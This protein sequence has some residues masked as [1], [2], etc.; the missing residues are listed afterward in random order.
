MAD[1]GTL[2][3][4]GMAIEAPSLTAA[5]TERLADMSLQAMSP[6]ALMVA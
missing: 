1:T 5:L 6:E 2:A 3:A 4:P